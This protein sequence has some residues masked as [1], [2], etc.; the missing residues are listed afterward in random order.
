LVRVYNTELTAAQVALLYAGNFPGAVSSNVVGYWGCW[1]GSGTSLFDSS[2]YKNNGTIA[3]AV[4]WDSTTYDTSTDET[5]GTGD[6]S[7]TDF[8][9][10]YTNVDT[11]PDNLTVTVDSVAKYIGTDFD[12]TPNGAI[13]FHT[14]PSTDDAIVATYRFYNMTLE[15]GGFFS[16]SIDRTCSVHETTDFSSAGEKTFI[17]GLKTWTATAERHWTN[18]QF[19]DAVGTKYLARFY[20]DKDNT[21]YF[22]GWTYITGLHPSSAVDTL[23]DETIDFQGIGDF[24]INTS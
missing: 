19:E 24:G 22:A 8:A 16:W 21:K 7:T 10:D 11:D 15:A 13:S 14:A 5:V 18:P 12:L 9:F 1:K 2:T 23:V 3:T 20:H 6:G 17:T 4:M